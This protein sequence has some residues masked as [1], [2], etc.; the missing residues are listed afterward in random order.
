MPE[1]KVFE[2]SWLK[3]GDEKF[4]DH[5][6]NLLAQYRTQNP[7]CKYFDTYFDRVR[8]QNYVGM[9]RVGDLTIEVLPKT[10][11]YSEDTELWQNVL[12]EMLLINLKV[13]AKT[14]TTANIHI[15]QH[16]VL[17]TYIQLFIDEVKTLVHR[18]LVK[19]Y[20]RIQGNST[21]LKGKLLIQQQVSKNIVHAERFFIEHQIYDRNNIYN[22]IIYKALSC[23]R[24]L[25][26]STSLNKDAEN[27]L[28]SFPECDDLIVNEMLFEN[29]NFDR[30]T[31]RY[32]TAIQFAR[33]ILLN[34]HPDIKHGQNNILAIM[35]DMNL[36]W[37]NYIYWALKKESHT[38]DKFTVTPQQ[39]KPFWEQT[40]EWTLHLKPDLVIEQVGKPNIVLDTKWKYDSKISEHDIR[41]MYAYGN[42]FDSLNSYLVY[43]DKL[44]NGNFVKISDGSFLPIEENLASDL[45]LTNKNEEMMCGLMYV[46]LIRDGKLNKDIGEAIF[47]TLNF[48]N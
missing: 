39:R 4:R 8:F 48:T 35:F 43:P 10:D 13:E 36:L 20:R 30:K 9:I 26:V 1:I 27:L 25:S 17:A 2:Y 44:D 16:S 15:R 23:I 7:N 5:H 12:I 22:R 14:T 31:E 3:V 6:L 40:N 18:G 37:E 47:K 33:I 19:K 45:K 38:N 11:R 28:L 34:Y 24:Q 42:Y 32:F 46:D 21:A 29:L 41:Q